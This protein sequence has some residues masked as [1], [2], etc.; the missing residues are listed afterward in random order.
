M[1][2]RAARISHD[3]VKRMVKA[4][5]GC[6][7]SVAR[8]SFD[9]ARVEVIIGDSGEGVPPIIDEA[10]NDDGPIREPQL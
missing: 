7:L 10:D 9:G 4:V 1:T 6:G 3:E 2:R 5:Q 8:V